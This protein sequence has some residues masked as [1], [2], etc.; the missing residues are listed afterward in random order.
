MRQDQRELIQSTEN[1]LVCAQAYGFEKVA[2]T[3]K[4]QLRCYLLHAHC[5]S[6][7]PCSHCVGCD[8]AWT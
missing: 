1:W 8:V 6:N 5:P 4:E 7:L 3:L 2:E